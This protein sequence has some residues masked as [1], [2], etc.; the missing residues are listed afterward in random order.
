MSGDNGH[1]EVVNCLMFGLVGHVKLVR[2]YGWIPFA[3]H[4]LGAEPEGA[5]RKRQLQSQIVTF[6]KAKDI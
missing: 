1:Q 6:E 5:Q 3:G 2:K 4:F